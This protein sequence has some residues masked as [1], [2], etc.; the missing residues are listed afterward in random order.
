MQPLLLGDQP[1]YHIIPQSPT[2]VST[3]DAVIV[4]VYSYRQFSTNGPLHVAGQLSAD[5]VV[6]TYKQLALILLYLVCTAAAGFV[7]RYTARTAVLY[8]VQ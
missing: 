5:A 1:L 2:I 7:F 4:N 3:V 8:Q 6:H